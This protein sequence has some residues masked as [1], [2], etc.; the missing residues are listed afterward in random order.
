MKEITEKINDWHKKAFPECTIEAIMY[1]VKEEYVE[2]VLAV[3]QGKKNEI[4]DEIADCFIS[5]VSSA[6]ILGI[7]IEK[8]IEDKFE[9]VKEKYHVI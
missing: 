3:G 1:K 6:R 8:A 9:R 4:S 7:D 5:L 2:F